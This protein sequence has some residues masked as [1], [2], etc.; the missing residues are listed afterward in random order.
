MRWGLWLLS[1]IPFLPVHA[2]N[3]ARHSVLIHELLP[4]PIPSRG[5]PNAEFIELKNVSTSDIQLRNWR[6]S[7]GSTTGKI[8]TNFI[9]KPDSLVIL[10]SSGSLASFQ[11]FGSCISLTPFPTLNNEEDT[12]LLFNEKDSLIHAIAYNSSWYRNPVKK[13][14]GW[15]LEMIDASQPCLQSM[16]WMASTS[17]FGGTPGKP[18]L[19]AGS[20][21]DSTMPWIGRAYLADSLNLYI[22]MNEPMNDEVVSFTP[23]IDITFQQWLPPLFQV[24]Q[25]RLRQPFPKDSL[26]TLWLKDLTDCSGNTSAPLSTTIGRFASQVNTQCIVNEIL[27]DP[28]A[29]G[30]D[31]IEIYNRSTEPINVAQLMLANRTING[32]LSAA[33]PIITSPFPLLPNQYLLLTEDS[34]WIHRYYSPGQILMLETALPSFPDDEGTVV[35]LN[36]QGSV[37]DELQYTPDWHHPLMTTPQGV[38]LERINPMGI[39][40]QQQNWHSAASSVRYGTPG[41]QNSQTIMFPE[42]DGTLFVPSSSII[43]PDQD[44]YQDFVLFHYQLDQPGYLAKIEVYTMTGARVVTIAN[45]ELCGT[46]GEFRWDGGNTQHMPVPQGNYLVSAKFVHPG[47]QTKQAKIPL[48]VWQGQLT[49]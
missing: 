44:G 40:Q 43:S 22:Q 29:G 14:G 39:T 45:N 36:T 21:R 3:S 30:S 33:R 46:R 34:S 11:A 6:V 5:L 12:L 17:P 10:V 16:N 48:A 49:K 25:V 23:Q 28:P 32:L 4:D 38:S 31:Y 18:N 8:N 24:L 37:V 7:N 42:V 13:E 15:S 19:T 26:L 9:L 1:V 27:F 47:G 20:I 35:I 41:Y 2:Q